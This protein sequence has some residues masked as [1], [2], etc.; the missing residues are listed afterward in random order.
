VERVVGV[1]GPEEEWAGRLT[2]LSEFSGLAG[3]K[4]GGGVWGFPFFQILSKQIFKPL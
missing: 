2:R 3:E 4:E 1:A